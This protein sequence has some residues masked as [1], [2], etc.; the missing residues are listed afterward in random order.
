MRHS[1]EGTKPPSGAWLRVRTRTVTAVFASLSRTSPVVLS[2]TASA[3]LPPRPVPSVHVRSCASASQAQ[4]RVQLSLSH[5]PSYLP[6]DLWS[7]GGLA[8]AASAAR[9]N[10]NEEVTFRTKER[11]NRQRRCPWRFR[12]PHRVTSTLLS[13]TRT[14]GFPL[15]R[16]WTQAVLGPDPRIVELLIPRSCAHAQRVYRTS[17]SQGPTWAAP[18]Q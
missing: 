10:L 5:P 4:A 8:F 13:W 11:H 16:E 9:H 12:V 2:A 3:R 17:F 15:G 14:G 6:P 7:C 1:L 18:F